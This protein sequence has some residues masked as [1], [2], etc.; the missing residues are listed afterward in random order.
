[1]PTKEEKVTRTLEDDDET[2]TSTFVV[3]NIFIWAGSY[4]LVRRAS[5][6]LLPMGLAT[7]SRVYFDGR[8]LPC[9]R[10]REGHRR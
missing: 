5:R 10:A 7:V 1:M 3:L 2:K 8:L 9:S 6:T 4:V